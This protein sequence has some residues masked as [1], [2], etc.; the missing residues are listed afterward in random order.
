MLCIP[1]VGYSLCNLLQRDKPDS[2]AVGPL[3][4]N[5]SVSE[6]MGNTQSL[7]FEWIGWET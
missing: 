2:V 3:V 4:I 5:S 7:Y 6:A 1:A